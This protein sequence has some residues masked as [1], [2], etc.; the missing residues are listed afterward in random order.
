MSTALLFTTRWMRV[1]PV[2]LS[3]D[4]R[5]KL[6]EL[7][8]AQ[9]LECRVCSKCSRQSATVPASVPHPLE[10]QLRDAKMKLKKRPGD[11]LYQEL[12]HRLQ[13]QLHHTSRCC[14]VRFEIRKFD[15]HSALYNDWRRR[16]ALVS[17]S[18][19]RLREEFGPQERS[20]SDDFIIMWDLWSLPDQMTGRLVSIFQEEDQF[21]SEP[22]VCATMDWSG[23]DQTQ[24]HHSLCPTQR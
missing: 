6:L 3:E 10:K 19:Q 21:Q 15:N 17:V 2:I 24:E 9:E 12:V 14:G 11:S 20:R 13:S 4:T 7:R 5:E 23:I 8:I 16:Q 22:C 18:V 1:T